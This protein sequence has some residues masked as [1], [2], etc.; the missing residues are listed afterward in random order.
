MIPA[1]LAVSIGLLLLFAATTVCLSVV[2]LVTHHK[3]GDVSSL[4][5]NVRTLQHDL[6]DLDERHMQ[7]VK[8]SGVRASK[9]KAAIAA[10]A[11]PVDD[12]DKLIDQIEM[13][14]H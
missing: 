3:I 8:R 4:E 7:F 12:I 10:A 5:A 14:H 2:L 13:V 6:A 9:E 1:L 11:P